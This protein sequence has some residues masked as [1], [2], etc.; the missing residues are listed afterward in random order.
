VSRIRQEQSAIK[1][2]TK[3]SSHQ[4]AG[5]WQLAQQKPVPSH[6]EQSEESALFSHQKKADSFPAAS[7]G[8]E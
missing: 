4:K 3:I 8:P 6:S 7:S 1:T 2:V 5:H